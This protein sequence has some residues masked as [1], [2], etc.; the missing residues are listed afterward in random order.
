MTIDTRKLD[1]EQIPVELRKL[2]DHMNNE[3][4]SDGTDEEWA[5]FEETHPIKLGFGDYEVIV[6]MCAASY[7]F[8]QYCLKDMADEFEA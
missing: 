4:A 3:F 7:N 6:P 5:E 2:Y 8:L 1:W